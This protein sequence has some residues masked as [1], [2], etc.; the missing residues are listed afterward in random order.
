MEVKRR[1]EDILPGI[2]FKRSE[3][4]EFLTKLRN[5]SKSLFDKSLNIEYRADDLYRNAPVEEDD[6]S[7]EYVPRYKDKKID[8][9]QDAVD[10]VNDCGHLSKYAAYLDSN[11]CMLCDKLNLD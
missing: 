3:F 6:K 4:L 7:I 1:A 5:D 2:L 10:F 11:H 8:Q 9:Y